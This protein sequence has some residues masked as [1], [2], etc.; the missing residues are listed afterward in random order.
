MHGATLSPWLRNRDPELVA[1]LKPRHGPC[2]R[3]RARARLEVC[4]PRATE[5]QV[6]ETAQ[7]PNICQVNAEE[8]VNFNAVSLDVDYQRC[9][10]RGFASYDAGAFV[11]EVYGGETCATRNCP[12]CSPRVPKGYPWRTAITHSNYRTVVGFVSGSRAQSQIRPTLADSVKSS[13]T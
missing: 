12:S 4:V 11:A 6:G 8:A 7:C 10:S 1:V 9:R 5:V 13:P 2:A 3:R